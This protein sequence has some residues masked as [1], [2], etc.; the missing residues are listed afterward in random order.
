MAL[1]SDTVLDW[2]DEMVAER[3]YDT[4]PAMAL[5][6]SRFGRNGEEDSGVDPRAR[7]ARSPRINPALTAEEPCQ[8]NPPSL[9]IFGVPPECLQG[10]IDRDI[11]GLITIAPKEC[12][13]ITFPLQTANG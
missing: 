3:G 9:P 11:M 8:Q 6:A 12:D 7:R 13:V 1:A 4:V 5:R 10:R 2:S